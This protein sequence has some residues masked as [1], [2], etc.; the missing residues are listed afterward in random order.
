M[1]LRSSRAEF[2]RRVAVAVAPAALLLASLAGS[3]TASTKQ[4]SIIQDDRLFASHDLTI[5]NEAFEVAANNLGADT[6]HTIVLWATIAPGRESKTKPSGFNASDPKSY[7]ADNWDR[8]DNLVVNAK[9]HGMDVLMTPAGPIPTWAGGC[10]SLGKAFPYNCRPKP[11]EY[12]S[13]VTALAK[14]YSGTYKDENQGGRTLPK[15]NRYSIWNE[16]NEKGWIQPNSTGVNAGIYRDL[17]Y[18]GLAGLT[19]GGAKKATVLLGET[20][21]LH[22]ALLFWQNLLCLDAKGNPLKGTTATKAKCTPGKKLKKFDVEGI[23]HHP[24]DR[25]GSPPFK[26]PK[27]N[28]INLVGQ[29]KLDALLA[30]AG[31]AGVLRKNIPVYY[32]EF[33]VSTK[34]EEK[35]FGVSYTDQAESINRAEFVGYNA[36]NILSYAQ[37]ALDN[38]R[39][40][41]FFQTGLRTV[42]MRSGAVSNKKPS[43]DAYRMP[44]YVTGKANSARVWGGVRI[45]PTSST[46]AIQVGK[47]SSFRTVKTVKLSKY[48]YIDQAKVKVGSSLVRL[49]WKAPNGFV[50]HSREAK[51]RQQ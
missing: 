29:S 19:K 25:G 21:P 17:V 22:N 32:T 9:A 31:K 3:A 34:P 11:K 50:L 12:Q 14:R 28:D 7:P 46:V 15:I 45:A 39:A 2:V 24:Y 41:D 13:F 1:F 42:D 51:V 5:Q 47:G 49:E 38:D 16:P 36:K 4:E 33:G 6:V 23:A 27:K 44:L 35:K 43:F 37:Y 8:Y 18:A 30:L 40:I 10:K 48:G 26:N 20:A